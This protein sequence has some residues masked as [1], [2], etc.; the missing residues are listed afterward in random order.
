M[1]TNLPSLRTRLVLIVFSAT[2]AVWCAAGLMSYQMALREVGDLLDGQMTQSA[3]LL[4]A[5]IRHEE[6]ELNEAGMVTQMLEQ[7][8]NHPYEQQLEFQVWNQGGKLLL[9]SSH[10]PHIAMVSRPGFTNIEQDG[11]DWRIFTINADD[12]RFQVQ[13]AQ[14]LS[15]RLQAALTVASQSTIPMLLALPILALILYW[16]IRRGLG[17]LDRLAG[18]MAARTPDRLA[19]LD[20]QAA[21]RETRPLITAINTLMVRLDAALDNE[22]RFTADAAHELRTPLSAI[23]VH[24]QVALSC[25]DSDTSRRALNQVLAGTDR[26]ARLVEQLLRLARLDPLRGLADPKPIEL[27]KLI[28]QEVENLHPFAEAAGQTLVQSAGSATIPGDAEMLSLAL[29]N[30]VEN[31]I[32]HTPA[33]GTV[34]VGLDTTA[35]DVRLWVRDTGPG[36]PAEEM[37]KLMERFYRGGNVTAEGSGLGLAIVQRIASLHGAALDLENL[38]NGGLQ[39][40]LAFSSARPS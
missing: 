28:H 29:R 22:R 13:V 37:P 9:R 10:A 1:N 6:R 26:A 23:K 30:L 2:L 40:S 5:Q 19:P 25:Q 20:E 12:S 16:G 14:A 17:P 36:V 24:A 11:L 18:D 3:K 38:Q 27:A 34:S 33:G 39:A 8:T 4:L 32:R 31:A 21:L 7:L 35:A 15:G